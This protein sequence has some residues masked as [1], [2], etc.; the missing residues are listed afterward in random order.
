MLSVSASTTLSFF[1]LQSFPA[2]GSFP[3][4]WF[5]T[6]GGQNIGASASESFCQIIFR[7]ISFTIDQFH[8][9]DT[10]ESS[11]A[12][13]FKSIYSTVLSLIFRPAFTYMH[14]LS[15][16]VQWC[17]NVCD[18]MDCSTPGLP[19]QQQH[20]EPTQ[21]HV[22]HV[23]DAFQ[24]SHPLLSP[25]PPAFNL[26][27]YQGLFQLVLPIRWPKYQS[28][29]FSIS[30]SKEYSGLFSFRIDWLNLPAVQGTLK[31][32]LQHHRSKISVL[33]HSAFFIV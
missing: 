30:L 10:Q 11:L 29:S 21:T 22:H 5:F 8:P 9:K 24:Q 12:T 33:W 4:S 16:V 2:S 23:S 31:S 1:C 17:P 7:L 27:Q 3:M 18:P 19:V 6:S 15:S 13:Q 28:F 32:L 14:Q 25:S 26:S 20:P